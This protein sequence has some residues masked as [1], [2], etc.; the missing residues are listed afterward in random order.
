AKKGDE[1]GIKVKEYVRGGDKVYPSKEEFAKPPAPQPAAP[2]LV[3]KPVEFARPTLFKPM[4]PLKPKPE[5]NKPVP[6]AAPQAPKPAAK[7]ESKP[8]AK[9]EPNKD[10]S[11]I[12]FLGF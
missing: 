12:K 6:Q 10:Y 4:L 1:I 11:Q 7:P 5:A 3:Y 9:P 8:A 2:K